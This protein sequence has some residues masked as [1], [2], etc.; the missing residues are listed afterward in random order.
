MTALHVLEMLSREN[1]STA[2]MG[3]CA[4]A[5]GFHTQVVGGRWCE[6]SGLV[7]LE[8]GPEKTPFLVFYSGC[9]MARFILLPPK[10]HLAVW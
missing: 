9:S 7:V 4:V 6:H 5:G 2:G 1:T 8:L 10:A 3:S